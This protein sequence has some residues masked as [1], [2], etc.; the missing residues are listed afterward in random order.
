MQITLNFRAA[1]PDQDAPG[2]QNH[3]KNFYLKR[4]PGTIITGFMAHGSWLLANQITNR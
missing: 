3:V 4:I 2:T 1:A